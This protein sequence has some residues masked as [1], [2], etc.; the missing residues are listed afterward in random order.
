MVACVKQKA[1]S[2]IQGPLHANELYTTGTLNLRAFERL[3]EVHSALACVELLG[4]VESH[5]TGYQSVGTAVITTLHVGDHH[6]DPLLLSEVDASPDQILMETPPPMI[7]QNTCPGEYS[8]SLIHL[9]LALSHTG[10]SNGLPLRVPD[11]P[12][13]AVV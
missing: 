2:F 11:D 4:G 5:P 12:P 8:Y 13:P 7:F 10:K 3:F 9:Q 1:V 6:T